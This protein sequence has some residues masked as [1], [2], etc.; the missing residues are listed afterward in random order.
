[1]RLMADLF[2]SSSLGDAQ[3]NTENRVR[4]E[5]G[6]VRRSIEFVKELIYLG[7][8]LDINVL[9]DDGRSNDRVDVVDGLEDTLSTP[10]RFVA[11]T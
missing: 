2:S 7:L 1:M 6:L 10:L 11:I 3:A 5:I 4:T 9:L 8:V